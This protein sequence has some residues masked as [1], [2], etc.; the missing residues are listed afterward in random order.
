MASCFISAFA[1][2]AIALA[3]PTNLLLGAALLLIGGVSMGLSL[4]GSIAV[5]IAGRRMSGTSSGLMDAHGYAYAG[6]QALVFS[7]VLDMT[8]SPWPIV[9]LCMAATRVLSAGDDS[10]RS[11]C[12]QAEWCPW[13][14]ST[15]MFRLV[16]EGRYCGNGSNVFA[17]ASSCWRWRLWV[18]FA[19]VPQGRA[20]F[21]TALFVL[22]VLELGVKPQSWFT[23][24]AGA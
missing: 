22:Q 17:W 14:K 7:V 11:G 20:A 15:K 4:I 2:V 9:F 19:V 1:L 3:P 13:L 8:G 12:S 16:D 23:K 18:F 6:L 21:H 5:D 24:C 10:R